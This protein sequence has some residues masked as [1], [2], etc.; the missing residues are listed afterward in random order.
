M[1][2]SLRKYK[3]KKEIIYMKK[4]K[5]KQFHE[6]EY[7]EKLE[8]NLVRC[9]LCPRNCIIKMNDLGDCKARQNINGK[10]YA[11]G[12]NRFTSVHADPIEKKPLYHYKPGTR[13]MSFGSAG[14][15]LHCDFCQ[16]W[17]ISQLAATNN[18]LHHVSSQEAISYTIKNRCETIAFTYNEPLINFEWIKETSE[19]AHEKNLGTILVSNGLINEE[20][21]KELIPLIDAANIDI[22]S[23]EIDFYKDICHFPG[24]ERIKKNVK[25]MVE[26]GMHVELT[27][28]IIPGFNDNEESISEFALWV[29][30]ELNDRVPVHFSR[31][32]PHFRMQHVSPTPPETIYKAREIALEKGLK[33]VFVGNLP[34]EEY[35]HT[36][37]PNCKAILVS[38][39][40]YSTS[41]DALEKDGTCGKCK[42]KTDIVI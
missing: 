40:F 11:L 32:Y 15:N 35:N 26:G 12:Y 22:K 16:N 37:C 38:R 24:L 28:L 17:T 34:A 6:A 21:L 41:I 1:N 27:M 8:D 3:K 33:Y 19:L 23:F 4:M 10:L 36:I 42:V 31:F 18:S 7:Y 14:C 2:T 9:R 13:T 5:Q 30:N 25:M 20:P 29:K 39:Y